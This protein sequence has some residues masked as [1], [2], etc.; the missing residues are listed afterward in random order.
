MLP[1]VIGHLLFYA[2]LLFAGAGRL[3]WLAAWVFLALYCGQLIVTDLRLAQLDPELARERRTPGK[4][5][6]P[7]RWDRRY[8]MISALFGPAWMLLMAFD[9]GRFGW[10]KLP[11]VACLP[12]TLLM[13]LGKYIAYAGLRANRF[14]STIVRLQSDRGQHV[15]D[16][17]PYGL[18]RH[19]IYAG[20]FLSALGAP[21]VLGSAWGLI[22]SG[23]LIALTARRA[24]LEERFLS[25]QLPG[26]RDYAA[27][28]RWRVVPGLF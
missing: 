28:I 23:L 6:A 9:A 19:P 26:Y 18:V 2:L 15:V 24:V 3:D 20:A 22:G 10:S 7:P 1:L 27:R 14:A 16:G 21:L 13:M 8:L 4:A 17:G 5:T 11:A 12:G 25:E